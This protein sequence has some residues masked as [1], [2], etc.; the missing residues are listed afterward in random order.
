MAKIRVEHEGGPIQNFSIGIKKLDIAIKIAIIWVYKN[1]L[2]IKNKLT[3]LPIT[4]K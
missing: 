3:F 4:S 2:T 1:G